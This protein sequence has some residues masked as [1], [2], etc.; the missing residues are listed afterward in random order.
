MLIPDCSRPINHI[1]TFTSLQ[2]VSYFM[3]ALSC[4][5]SV[6]IVVSDNKTRSTTDLNTDQH[7]LLSVV[8]SEMQTVGFLPLKYFLISLSNI[9]KDGE[10]GGSIF[11]SCVYHRVLVSQH[12]SFLLIRLPPLWPVVVSVLQNCQFRA[13]RWKA[14]VSL[15]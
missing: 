9:K 7:R 13:G 10:V 6:Y 14:A 15:Q 12:S 2:N 8:I 11:H 1:H 4:R 5:R 3:S